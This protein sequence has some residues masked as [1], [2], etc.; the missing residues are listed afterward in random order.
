LSYPE[1]NDRST[2]AG[3]WE[4]GKR[5]AEIIRDLNARYAETAATTAFW[6]SASDSLP[7]EHHSSAAS[8]APQCL[9]TRFNSHKA[10][11]RKEATSDRR[12]TAQRVRKSRNE[13][14]LNR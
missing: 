14:H 6:F 1:S 12:A 10:A 8:A 4:L 2:G 13:Q 5:T 9:P 11:S 7:I 3:R